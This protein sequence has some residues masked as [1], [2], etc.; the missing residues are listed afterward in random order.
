MSV[1]HP[2]LEHVNVMY[3]K[4]T[5]N[6]QVFVGED[7][8]ADS[9]VRR[10]RKAVMA[11]GVIPE[12]RRRRYHETPQDIVKRK[13]KDSHR[14]KASSR[15]FNGPRPEGGFG[16]RKETSAASSDD[17]DFWGYAEEGADTNL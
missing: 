7:E 1:L 13:Q 15:R 14:R 12:C 5:Y 9:V 11:T 16:D 6:T 2:G 3:F 10:F 8:P 4:G 17:D